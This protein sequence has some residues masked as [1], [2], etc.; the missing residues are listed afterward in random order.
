VS[1]AKASLAQL[2][3]EDVLAGRRDP[4]PI[5]DFMVSLAEVASGYRAMDQRRAIKAW[6]DRHKQRPSV[7]RA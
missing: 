5:L 3:A 7:P 4:S 6:I 1:C 2:A